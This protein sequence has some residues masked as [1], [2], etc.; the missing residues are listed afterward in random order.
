M[1]LGLNDAHYSVPPN[2]LGGYVPTCVSVITDCVI[3]IKIQL[4]RQKQL[5]KQSHAK[6]FF[7]V[8]VSQAFVLHAKASL[9]SLR[10]HSNRL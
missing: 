10:E 3:P 9:T 5:A 1:H 6:I 2:H 8:N 7:N 4:S